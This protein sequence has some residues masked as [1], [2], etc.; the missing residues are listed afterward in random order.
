MQVSPYDCSPASGASWSPGGE[1]IAVFS[2]FSSPTKSWIVNTER[3]SQSPLSQQELWDLVWSPNGEQ[4]AFAIKKE[5][6]FRVGTMDVDGQNFRELTMHD[7]P[8]GFVEPVWSP[9]SKRLAFVT[10]VNGGL[11][12]CLIDAGGGDPHVLTSEGNCYGPTFSLWP[13][14][15]LS[16]ADQRQRRLAHCC[17]RC[18][19][20]EPAGVCL[21]KWL[22][23]NSAHYFRVE[24]R[25]KVCE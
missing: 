24:A 7:N 25:Q 5:A 17:D 3:A 21:A 12:V 10:W 19:W 14:D 15:S 16:R 20:Q 1:R 9:D 6:G 11:N 23:R 4:F 18:G 13:E 8:H 22:R 2:A